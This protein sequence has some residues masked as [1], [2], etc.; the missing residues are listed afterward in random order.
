MNK[1]QC[2]ELGYVEKPHGIQGDV[3]I[4]LD[5]DDPSE[6]SKL[7]SVFVEINSRLVP[8]FIEKIFP[9]PKGRFVVSFED[10]DDKEQAEKVTSCKLWLPLDL[11]PQLSGNKF[12]F[13]E[14]IGFS[15]VDI[16]QGDI[17]TINS[18]YNSTNQDILAVDHKGFEVLVPVN[19]QI[20]KTVNR[21]E[22]FVEVELPEGLIDIYISDD[23]D[24]ENDA[25]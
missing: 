4:Y 11:L 22:Q 9:K 24:T 1:D 25:D 8:F 7:E 10:V 17:G 12:Y 14:I 20:I 18:V 23:E 16:H 13:H 2:Y 15:V 21:S 3:Q 19:D 6:Y 5:V